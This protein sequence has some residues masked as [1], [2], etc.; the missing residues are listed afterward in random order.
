MKSVQIIDYGVGNKKSLVTAIARVGMSS[1]L[2]SDPEIIDPLAPI[3][4]PGVGSFAFCKQRL[5]QAGLFD[6]LHD[7]LHNGSPACFVGI[8]VGMQLLFGK[9]VE[10][11]SN[12]GFGYFRGEIEDLRQVTTITGNAIPRLPNTH[13]QN[14]T[15]AVHRGP[16]YFTHSYGNVGSPDRSSFYELGG[17]EV[18]ASASRG[19]VTGFQFHP[20]KSA[21]QGLRL[22]SASLSGQSNKD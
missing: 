8:C 1:V 20:E 16:Y 19:T 14:V 5:V 17:V 22:L 13:W 21:D 9:S 10:D 3:L 15:G 18:T 2:V 6:P 4:L 12:A 7:I 11:G